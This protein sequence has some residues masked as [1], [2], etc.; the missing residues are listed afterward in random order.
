MV[1]VCGATLFDGKWSELKDDEGCDRIAECN[2]KLLHTCLGQVNIEREASGLEPLFSLSA[3]VYLFAI[4]GPFDVDL[5]PSSSVSCFSRLTKYFTYF[6][7]LTVD[8]LDRITCRK[9]P[10]N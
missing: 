9:R 3:C 10:S 2:F 5:R 6:R 4:E 7:V 8:Q 1:I